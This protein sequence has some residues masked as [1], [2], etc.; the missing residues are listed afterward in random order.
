[1]FAVRL[2]RHAVWR[3]LGEHR[4]PARGAVPGVLGYARAVERAIWTYQVPVAGAFT[5]Y[6][7]VAVPLPGD[8]EADA[9]LAGLPAGRLGI[10]GKAWTISCRGP[11]DVFERRAAGGETTPTGA[12]PTCATAGSAA[13]KAC[14][15]TLG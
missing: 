12:A 5:W 11:N 8:A 6:A 10:A 4:E 1:M 15:G 7:A 9:S 2:E 13:A 3:M 14:C